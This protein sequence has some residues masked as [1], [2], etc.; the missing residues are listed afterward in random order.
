MALGAP[1]ARFYNHLVAFEGGGG[2]G[3]VGKDE[4]HRSYG[5]IAA[6]SPVVG[7]KEA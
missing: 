3:K 7:R 2:A 1:G 6:A 5:K 4:V